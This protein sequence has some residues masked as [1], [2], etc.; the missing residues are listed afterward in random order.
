[1]HGVYIEI[2]YLLYSIFSPVLAL[3]GFS[4]FQ[5]GCSSQSHIHNSHFLFKFSFKYLTEKVLIIFYFRVQSS[6]RNK[7]EKSTSSAAADANLFL[8]ILFSISIFS[9]QGIETPMPHKSILLSP[10]F[11]YQGNVADCMNKISEGNT[12]STM[13]EVT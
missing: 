13:H 9:F 1:M 2:L 12:Q 8:Q 10:R 11:S 6:V 7:G 5:F 3:R 4:P